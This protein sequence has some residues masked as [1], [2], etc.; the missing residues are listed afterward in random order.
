MFGG[1]FLGRTHISDGFP[2]NRIGAL[3]ATYIDRKDIEST[4]GTILA[5]NTRAVKR[6]ALT[7]SGPLRELVWLPEDA[8]YCFSYVHSYVLRAVH[9]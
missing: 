4:V 8:T 3:W 5:L 6:Y 1:P 2:R 9:T 7:A